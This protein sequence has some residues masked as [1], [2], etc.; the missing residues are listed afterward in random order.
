MSSSAPSTYGLDKYA[1]QIM[2][3]Y[4]VPYMTSTIFWDF[5]TP[6]PLFVRKTWTVC[7]QILGI[8]WRLPPSVRT[9]YVVAP[10]VFLWICGGGEGRRGRVCS[11]EGRE[12]QL[13][14]LI[15]AYSP[16]PYSP[17]PSSSSPFSLLSPNRISQWIQRADDTFVVEAVKLIVPWSASGCRTGNKGKLSNSW[18]DGQTWLCLAAA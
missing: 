2:T 12:G 6:S 9:S 13:N 17:V 18:F 10:Y 16:S 14:G 1:P 7:P 4:G 8:T 5:L 11:A 3:W 15:I